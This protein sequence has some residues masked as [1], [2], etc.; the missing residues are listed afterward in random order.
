[1]IEH[2]RVEHEFAVCQCD[3]YPL[4]YRIRVRVPTTMMAA[5]GPNSEWIEAEIARQ[6]EL[7]L[8]SLESD[9][10]EEEVVQGVTKGQAAL[11]APIDESLKKKSL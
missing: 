9:S 11:D 1:M 5:E 8:V 3:H 7:V 4:K 2:A 6:L 10:E